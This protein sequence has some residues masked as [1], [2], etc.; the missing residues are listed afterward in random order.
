MQIARDEGLLGYYRGFSVILAGV[1][2]ANMA[3]F[4]GYELGKS[5]VPRDSGMVGHMATGAIAQMIAG[6]VFNPIDIVKE[7]MQVQVS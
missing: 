5:L 6:V 4:G 1:I 2:P 7:R 3:Y